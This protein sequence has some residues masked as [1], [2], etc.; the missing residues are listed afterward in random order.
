MITENDVYSL[1]EG[2]GIEPYH[3]KPQWILKRYNNFVI[4][5]I[6][7][8]TR[9]SFTGTIQT[10]EYYSGTGEHIL[11]LN[12]KPI[13]SLDAIEHITGFSP[14]VQLDVSSIEVIAAQ[15]LLR[16]KSNYQE[17]QY[18]NTF[19]RG[20]RN[21]KIT[22]TYGFTDFPDDLNE[23]ALYLTTWHVL[24]HI[25]NATGG[26]DLSVEGTSKS[27]GGRGKYTELKNTLQRMAIQTMR[28]Y[29]TGVVGN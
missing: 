11:I 8:K 18:S 19:A 7:R 4:P 1:L 20:D 6:E 21:I 5:F 15:G 9:Q 17:G 26:G 25:A 27:Y 13:I 12:R 2:Y 24:N 29:M 16:A 23:A 3:V 14:G 10:S 22:Y 28:R